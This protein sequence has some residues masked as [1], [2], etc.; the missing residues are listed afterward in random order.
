VKPTAF[1]TRV[2]RQNYLSIYLS[3]DGAN[4]YLFLFLFCSDIVRRQE[5][6]HFLLYSTNV[7]GI[8][9]FDVGIKE[10]RERYLPVM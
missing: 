1:S 8:E 7:W 3:T 2:L 5:G 4:L 10:K 6:L 9:I